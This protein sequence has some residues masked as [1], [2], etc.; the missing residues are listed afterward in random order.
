MPSKTRPKA[1]VKTRKSKKAARRGGSD[2]KKPEVMIGTPPASERFVKDLLVRGEAAPLDPGGKLPLEA[3]HVIE[4]QNQDGTAS[5][6][7]L[8]YKLF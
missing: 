4:K 6:R 8:R 1:R 7:R 5:V 3:T 2:V